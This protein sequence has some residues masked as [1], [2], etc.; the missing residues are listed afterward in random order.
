MEQ[1]TP[2]K[3]AATVGGPEL[4]N[5]DM[6]LKLTRQIGAVQKGIQK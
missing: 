1:P 2:S 3:P 6:R 4:V 5:H